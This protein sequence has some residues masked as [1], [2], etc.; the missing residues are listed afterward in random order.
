MTLTETTSE[1]TSPLSQLLRGFSVEITPGDERSIDVA[2]KTLPKNTETFIASLP[3]G[4]LDAVVSAAAR[5]RRGGLIPVPHLAARNLAGEAQ[6]DALLERLR[7]EAGVDR[8]LVIAGDRPE[9]AG[10]YNDSLQILQSGLLEKHGLKT[11]Y[12]SCYP[13]GHPRIGDQQLALARA[14]KL[15][16]A[17]GA[18]FRVGF[19]SQFCFETEP[20]VRLAREIRAEGIDEP[21]RIGLAGPT[22]AAVL[23]KYALICG[24][25]PS[26]RALRERDSLTKNMVSGNPEQLL[27]HLAHAQKSE[28]ALSINGVHFF[29]FGALSR[30][31][32]MLAQF[33]GQKAHEFT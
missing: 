23:L 26:I 31:T 13:E 17:K 4:N 22:G 19:V 28:P 29:T 12:L 7:S 20:M 18:A 10:V 14:E 33:L 24:I 21:L 25:G 27:A 16:L 30:T 32:D 1:H 5:L 11:V 3:K 2:V 6:L 8:A 9:P 15:R